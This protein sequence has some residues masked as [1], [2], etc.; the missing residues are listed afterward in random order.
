MIISRATR[1]VPT[2]G[3]IRIY[4]NTETG[5]WLG[6]TLNRDDKIFEVHDAAGNVLFTNTWDTACHAWAW[7]HIVND[8]H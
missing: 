2:N 7:E 1:N 8:P 3:Y 4:N 5:T 6:V